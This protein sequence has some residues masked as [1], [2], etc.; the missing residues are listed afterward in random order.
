MDTRLN[1]FAADPATMKAFIDFSMGISPNLIDPHLAHLVKIRASQLNGCANCLHMHA[2]EA[3]KDGESE[4]RIL[5][6]GAWEEAPLYTDRERAAL[7]WTDA[8]TLLGESH[9]P[10]HVYDELTAHFSDD[11]IVKL[12]MTIA[13]INAWNRFG[14]GLRMTQ[15]FGVRKAAA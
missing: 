4:D 1:P 3:R 10:R 7:A 12:T 2:A 5:L 15:S 14:A 9:A 6:T 8:L 13:L 11:E